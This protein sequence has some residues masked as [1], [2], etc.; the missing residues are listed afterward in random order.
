MKALLVLRRLAAIARP[1][2]RIAC[3]ENVGAFSTG[4][5]MRLRVIAAQQEDVT[6]L[7][8]QLEELAAQVEDAAQTVA[9]AGAKVRGANAQCAAAMTAALGLIRAVTAIHKDQGLSTSNRARVLEVAAL[10]CRVEILEVAQQRAAA[11]TL[12][13]HEDAL[14]TRLGITREDVQRWA[15][16]ESLAMV[17]T[18]VAA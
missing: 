2:W 15:A 10:R 3:S 14:L 7:R 9:V 11:A 5:V 4:E 1:A 13:L 6:A 18:G 16:P 17:P 12:M 8:A